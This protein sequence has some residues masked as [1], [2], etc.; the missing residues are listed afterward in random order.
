MANPLICV[1]NPTTSFIDEV[2]SV[3]QGPAAIG[4]P[5]VT[6][7]A[8]VIDASLIGSGLSNVTA[9]ETVSPGSLVSLYNVGGVLKMQL[10]WAGTGGTG[11]SGQS[12]PIAAQGFVIL[13]TTVNGAGVVQ[14]GGVYNYVDNNTEFSANDVG[15]EVY[16]DIRPGNHGG[17]TKTRPSGVGQLQQTVGSVVNFTSPNIVQIAFIGIPNP[18]ALNFSNISTGTNTAATMTVGAGATITQTGGG[19][20]NANQLTGDPVNTSGRTTGQTLVFNGT[21]WVPSNS[22]ATAFSAITSGTNTTAAMVVG[23]GASITVAGSGSITAT[24]LAT[25]GAAVVVSSAAPPSVGQVLTATSATAANWQTPGG[26]GGSPGG[27]ATNIQ[28]NAGG[29]NFGGVSGSTADGANGL[30]SIAPTGAGVA[31]SVTG[32][33]S[34]DIIEIF[35]NAASPVLSLN[36]FGVATHTVTRTGGTITTPFYNGTYVQHNTTGGG[37][38]I[39]VSGLSSN[40]TYLGT[41]GDPIVSLITAMTASAFIDGTSTDNIQSLTGLQVNANTPTAYVG[42]VSTGVFGANISAEHQGSGTVATVE[43]LS[44][45][46]GGNN[47]AASV[48]TVSGLHVQQPQGGIMNFTGTTDVSGVVV[49]NQSSAPPTGATVAALR[50]KSQTGTATSHYAILVDGGVSAFKGLAPSLVTKTSDYTVTRNDYAINVDATT[51]PNTF[52]VTAAANASFGTTDYT[53]TFTGGVG[54]AWVGYYITISGFG[55][56]NNNGSWI[57]TASSNTTITLQNGAGVA[58]AGG[59]TATWFLITLPTTNLVVNQIF[60]V[61]KIDTSGPP[62]NAVTVISTANI[63]FTTAPG[64]VGLTA[65]LQAVEVQWDGTQYWIY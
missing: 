46:A 7:T 2:Q 19:I 38:V 49:E 54:N 24:Q 31:L 6:N 61:K 20:I 27:I 42:N 43:A 40:V 62:T 53:G 21:T 30:I 22:P 32:D 57:C 59:A 17:V 60:R 50:I 25:T 13:G 37:T 41:A 34:S 3:S 28:F 14:F 52:V 15:A 5:I 8:G 51:P 45:T 39:S 55:N 64:S 10:A 11:P 16:L 48:T 35:T 56:A 29:G 1:F 9:G 12:Y 18:P 33:A 58:Q 4:V 63:D 23:S 44:V 26:G 36:K 47:Q 65:S